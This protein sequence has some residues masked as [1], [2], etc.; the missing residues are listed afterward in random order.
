[1]RSGDWRSANLKTGQPEARMVKGQAANLRFP[2]PVYWPSPAKTN[3]RSRQQRMELDKMRNRYT[4]Y[5]RTLTFLLNAGDVLLIK[6]SSTAH[7]FPGMYNGVGGHV[8]RG[9]DVLAA[10]QR[11]VREESGLDIPDLSLRCLLHVDE[12]ADRPGVLVFVF[13]GYTRRRDVTPSGEG[14]LRWVPL[15][16]VGKLN[17]VPD[18]PSLLARVAALPAGTAPVFAR[19]LITPDGAAWDI[20]FIE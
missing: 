4:V 14:E 2:P 18:L 9:E 12:G 11:E 15:T 20:Q 7:L 13:V 8:E 6:R 5:P 10:A 3:L 16:Q 17:L 1:M 19:S